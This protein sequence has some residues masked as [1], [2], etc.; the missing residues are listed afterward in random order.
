MT[1]GHCDVVLP[2]A[3]PTKVVGAQY[4]F[5]YGPFRQLTTPKQFLDRPQHLRA[6][7][8]RRVCWCKRFASVHNRSW[9]K[10]RLLI[11]RFYAIFVAPENKRRSNGTNEKRS[12]EVKHTS[13]AFPRTKANLS[14]TGLSISDTRWHWHGGEVERFIVSCD[15]ANKQKQCKKP[16][17]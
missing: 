9:T 5:R 16:S 11:L 6:I 8:F 15:S 12:I 2:F 14:N 3:A 7:S 1:Q 4:Q 13:Y 17:C 10:S